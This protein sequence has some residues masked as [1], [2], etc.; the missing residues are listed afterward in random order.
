M[1]AVFIRYQ[2][3]TASDTFTTHH[4]GLWRTVNLEGGPVTQ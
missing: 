1:V 2:P 3:A 4:V